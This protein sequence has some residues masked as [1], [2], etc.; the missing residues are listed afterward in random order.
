[1]GSCLSHFASVN[2]HSWLE[3]TSWFLIL[4]F[5]IKFKFLKWY[6][7]IHL[8]IV[9]HT[10]LYSPLLLKY[11]APV[12]KAFLKILSPRFSHWPWQLCKCHSL[13]FR[14]LL[15]TCGITP[16][17]HSGMNITIIASRSLFLHLHLPSS[18]LTSLSCTLIV[19]CIISIVLNC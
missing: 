18:E 4:L 12:K 6:F 8:L 13:I 2:F 3:F 7:I 19:F 11:Q 17:H 10:P 1:M 9:S 5:L 16:I 14:H 15:H